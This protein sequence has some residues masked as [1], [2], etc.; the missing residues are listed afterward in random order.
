MNSLKSRR[1]LQLGGGL[2][3]LLLMALGELFWHGALLARV[4]VVY[5]DLWVRLGTERPVKHVALV[6]LDEAALQSYP[7]DPLVFW[8]PQFARAIGVLRQA[9]VQVIGLDFHFSVSPEQWMAKVAGPGS[10]AA[11]A[12]DQAFRRELSS[13]KVVLAGMQPGAEAFLPAPDYLVVLP[14][15]D[16]RAHVGAADLVGDPDG[17]LRRMSALA[18][19][20]LLAQESAVRLL[21][22]P[23]L[24]AIRASGQDP[25]AQAWKFGGRQL[26]ADDPPWR[27]AWSGPPMTVE[28]L[29]MKALLAEDALNNPRVR[30]LAGKVVVIGP[31]YVGANDL[32]LTPYGYGLFQAR[33]M[34]GAEVH[35][36]SVEA[37]LSG[38]FVDE[39]PQWARMA[40]TL[41]VLAIGLA[42]WR[43]RS[44]LQGLATLAVLVLLLAVFAAWLY[45]R[46]WILPVAQMQLATLLLFLGMYGLRF[47]LGERERNRVRAMF[48]RYVSDSV[49]QAMLASPDMPRLGGQAAE[50][51]VLFSDIR[52]FTTL[53]ERLQPEEVVEMANRWFE[54]VCEIL[55]EEGGL[56][57]KFIGDAVMAEFGVP[58]A[59]PDHAR[60]AVRAALRMAAVAEELRGWLRQRFP[61]RDLPE[62]AVGVGLHSGVAVIGN[63]GSSQRMEYTAIGDTVNLA[64]RLEGL[65]KTLGCVVVASRATV[66]QVG[67]GLKTGR[68]ETLR[69][70]GREQPV[71]VLEIVG[72]TE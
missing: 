10:R 58:L 34:S 52:N 65:T 29:S 28:R 20:A 63:I 38:R 53:S 57:D 31:A 35:A 47:S 68:C 42:V 19:G 16:V 60:R 62:F 48:S 13:G 50:L 14:D 69:V 51:T 4:E 61:G 27:L 33:L 11:R 40:A 3:I 18:P 39:V 5:Q 45:P 9:G 26:R 70:K 66:D 23:M 59:Q 24:L 37:L 44:P 22:L 1:K 56:I 41:L 36:Q 15:F 2:L 25:G 43:F 46:G 7:D 49:V 67:P 64:S 32:H 21:S 55:R 6:E 12:H 71:E 8:T 17:A 72:L 30:A 54:L